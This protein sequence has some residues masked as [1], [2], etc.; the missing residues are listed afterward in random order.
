MKNL[1]PSGI[2]LEVE[3]HH[4][5]EAIKILG[6][7]KVMEAARYFAAKH[8]GKLPDKRPAEVLTEL[9]ADRTGQN[10]SK[11][12]VEDLQQRCKRFAEAFSCPIGSITGEEVSEFLNRLNLSP[13]SRNNFTGAIR[14]LFAFAK[15][16]KYLS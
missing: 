1:R 4:F 16:K 7:D 8:P 10:L 12:Y 15:S 14:T 13:R 2:A 9:I 3:T 6:G 11:R 5:A